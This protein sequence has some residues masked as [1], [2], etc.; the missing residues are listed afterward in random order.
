MANGVFVG[1][2][3]VRLRKRRCVLVWDLLMSKMFA[4][5]GER[6]TVR[7]ETSAVLLNRSVA[8]EK[9]FFR[10]EAVLVE[11][12]VQRAR[13]RQIEAVTRLRASASVLWRL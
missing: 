7:V 11:K 1:M 2:Q 9:A 5:K 6:A 3:E 10:R 13:N 12:C 8:C 4:S